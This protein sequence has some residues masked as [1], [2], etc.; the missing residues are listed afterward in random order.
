MYF[1]FADMRLRCIS[2]SASRLYVVSG[3]DG[4]P[5]LTTTPVH[6]LI[7]CGL[8]YGQ[9]LSFYCHFCFMRPIYIKHPLYFRLIICTRSEVCCDKAREILRDEKSGVYT[10]IQ[11]YKMVKGQYDEN[12]PYYPKGRGTIPQFRGQN[13]ASYAKYGILGGTS[14]ILR[15]FNATSS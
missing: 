10:A 9:Q 12:W 14:F 5:E 2:I 7:L 1:D 3:Q 15:T 8:F 13:M 6:A 11:K 4:T